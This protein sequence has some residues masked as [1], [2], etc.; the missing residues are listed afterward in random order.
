MQLLQGVFRVYHC[1]WLAPSQKASVEGCIRV[2]SDVG[3][4][5][6]ARATQLSPGQAHAGAQVSLPKPPSRP[7]LRSQS[8]P[9][10]RT[11]FKNRDS[12]VQC[13][14]APGQSEST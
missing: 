4:P 5:G 7:R 6:C 2:L 11:D 14:A 1:S 13:E 3:E 8:V 12:M 10:E 9:P